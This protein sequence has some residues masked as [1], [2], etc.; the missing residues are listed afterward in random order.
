M[1]GDNWSDDVGGAASTVIRGIHL[2]RDAEP[3]P[4]TDVISDL[5]GV[6]DLLHSE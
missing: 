5:Y 4:W 2:D 6:V 3:L 1:V